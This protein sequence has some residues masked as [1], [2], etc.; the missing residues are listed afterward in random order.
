MIDFAPIRKAIYTWIKTELD[1]VAIWEQQSEQRPPRP[2]VSMKLIVG[3]V[4]TGHDDLRQDTSG[5]FSVQGLRVLTL[6][7]NVYG[8]DAMSLMSRL[9]TSTEKPSVQEELRKEGI[10]FI[11]AEGIQDLTVALDNRFETRAQM[12][13]L[14]HIKDI[15]SDSALTT[16]DDVE[17]TEQIHDETVIIDT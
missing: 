3:P 8:Q 5:S 2:Y 12:D 1:V 17:V 9:Q 15:E 16:I 6:S 14:F 7:L 11:R 13:V 10:A 4:K